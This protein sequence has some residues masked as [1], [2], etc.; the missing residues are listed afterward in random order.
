MS[1]PF[2]PP[3]L[4]LRDFPF[5]PLDVTRLVDSDLAAIANGEEF[6]A[7]VILWCKSWH[8]IP[9]SSLPD[10]DRML[11]HLSGFGRDVKGWK[12]VREVALRGFVK[13]SDGRLYHPV[14]AEKALEAGGAKAI[15]AETQEASQTRKQREREDR[16]RMFSELRAAGIVPKWNTTTHE[17]RDL[18]AGL[19]Q[20]STVTS[21]T[22]VT[23]DAVTSHRT[24]HVTS[25]AVV[26]AMTGTGTG[27][28][29]V[30]EDDGIARARPITQELFKATDCALRSIP[31]VSSHPVA[32]NL[33]IGPI[34]RLVADQGLDLATQIVPSIRRQAATS[35]RPIK[36]WS[37]FVDGILSD[38]A[39]PTTDTGANRNGSHPGSRRKSPTDK[40]QDAFDRV[41]ARIAERD[42]GP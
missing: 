38:N 20:P 16:A 15:R 41:E 4:D 27:I 42:P 5:M 9:A 35:K 25:H 40:L 32:T 34:C 3:G 8:Q 13:C 36:L 22:P 14:I 11:A 39:T 37:Y 24:S 12:K 33:M 10:D 19:S 26:T 18:V 29:T 21:H 17:L 31:E 1:E 2:V 7:A 23:Q 30:E 6:K 28:G